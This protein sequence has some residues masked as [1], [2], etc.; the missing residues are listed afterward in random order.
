M[1]SVPEMVHE[2]G[3]GAVRSNEIG[4]ERWDLISGAAVRQLYDVGVLDAYEFS[5]MANVGLAIDYGWRFL[6]HHETNQ[7]PPFWRTKIY[8]RIEF[9]ARGWWSLASA[10]QLIDGGPEIGKIVR[11]QLTGF[12]SVDQRHY[13]YFALRRLAT[14]CDE[15]AKKY[16]EEN[17]LHGFKIKGLLNHGLRHM[18]KWTNGDTSEDHL[19]HSMWS[20]MASIHM[21]MFRRD[22]MCPLLLGSD[23]SMTE[24]IEAMHAE[25]ASRRKGATGLRQEVVEKIEEQQANGR[26]RTQ[27]VG[28]TTSQRRSRRK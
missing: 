3:T 16:A 10:I 24:E 6:G 5:P 2:E 13:P 18:A 1:S 15:G 17:W 7:P 22:D 8:D 20:F 9:L 14:T 19:G 21:W 23:Y 26:A 27:G 12:G 25:H 11:Q 28:T 4:A